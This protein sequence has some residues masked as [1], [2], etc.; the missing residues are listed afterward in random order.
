MVSKPI[1]L[2]VDVIVVSS[3]SPFVA[4][5]PSPL[6]TGHSTSLVPSPLSVPSRV[7]RSLVEEGHEVS[8]NQVDLQS[9]IHEEPI[10]R[11]DLPMISPQAYG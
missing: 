9:D 4:L 10:R 3:P 2:G 8:T 5:A 7:H 1:Q 6:P 11:V